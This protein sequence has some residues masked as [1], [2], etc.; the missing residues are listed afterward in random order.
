MSKNLPWI[1]GV[2]TVIVC[3]IFFSMLEGP[4]RCSDGWASS[5]I[6]RQG[7]CSSH[8]GVAPQFAFWLALGFGVGAGFLTNY[9]QS[10]ARLARKPKTIETVSDPI[11][12]DRVTTAHAYGGGGKGGSIMYCGTCSSGM[13]AV[14]IS[15]GP[16]PHGAFWE[17]TKGSCS[18]I[19]PRA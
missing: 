1:V 16:P 9:V 6:G 17:C 8:G 7:A 5:S 11:P 13:R 3:G 18:R 2:V 4:R 19:A 10:E 15:V 12:A 14:N